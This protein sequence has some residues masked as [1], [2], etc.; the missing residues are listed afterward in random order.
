MKVAVIPARGGSK[1]IPGKNVKLFAGKP[2]ISYS[3]NAALSCGLFD[4]IIVSTDSPEIAKVAKQFGAE[5]PF[6]R[7][8]E[9]ADDY[10]G[11]DAV[12]LDTLKRI[13]EKNISARYVCCL[14]ATVP[15]IRPADL[16]Q[17]YEILRSSGSC[18]AFT[19]TTFP[20]P[21]FR[22]LQAN[23]MD[24]LEMIWPQYRMTRSQDLP[25]AFHDAGQ[26]YWADVEKYLTEKTFWSSD[27]MPIPLPRYRVQDIDTPE[28]WKMA[29][30]M[31]ELL[32]KR[33]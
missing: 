28:D 4:R 24:Q 7:S 23:E 26:F 9:L 29:E 33:S 13:E 8:P 5:V 30:M 12:V 22:A 32:L 16:K 2:L 15:F 17:G 14:Y 18:S 19:V 20:A 21:I 1:R 10:S 31:F 6:L 11:T 25:E 3:I 27:A